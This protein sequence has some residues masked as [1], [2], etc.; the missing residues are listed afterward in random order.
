[1]IFRWGKK[2]RSLLLTFILGLA[3]GACSSSSDSQQE[4]I[5]ADQSQ[6]ATNG[7]SDNESAAADQGAN[8]ASGENGALANAQVNEAPAGEQGLASLIDDVSSANA[9]G[10]ASAQA[11]QPVAD[12]GA[13]AEAPAQSAEVSAPVATENAVSQVA[14]PEQ[15]Q[16]P[17]ENAVA[18][19]AAPQVSSMP[20]LPEMGTKLSYIVEKGDT[21]AKISEKVYGN[22]KMW[23]DLASLAGLSDPNKIYPGEVIYY[24]LSP[25]TS[26]FASSYEALGR[27]S[28]QVVKGDTLAKISM[29]VY[30]TSSKWRAIWRENEQVQDPEALTEGGVIYYVNYPKMSATNKTIP[31]IIKQN[32]VASDNHDLELDSHHSNTVHA[33]K[34]NVSYVTSHHAANDKV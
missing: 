13:A 6:E 27:S 17:V 10:D 9:A 28:V 22:A 3:G 16:A 30:G 29:K 12:A 5:E 11:E 34:S 31:S 23:K 24:Q 7:A 26:A 4:T 19:S 1:M 33:S 21:L 25:E 14:A 32:K 15:A 20:G 8:Q 18:P 2:S